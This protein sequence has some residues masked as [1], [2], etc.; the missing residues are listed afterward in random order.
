MNPY[1]KI[2]AS[3]KVGVMLLVLLFTCSTTPT[4]AQDDAVKRGETLFKGNCTS[5]H[6]MWKKMTGPALAGSHEKYEREWLYKW[7]KNSQAL[8]KAGDPQANAIFNEYGGSV[9]TSFA[10]SNEQIDDVL[11]YIADATAKGPQTPVAVEGGAASG[12]DTSGT[13]SMFMGIILLILFAIIFILSR[14]TGTLNNLV[15]EKMGQLV[16]ESVPLERKLFSKKMMAAVSLAGMILLGYYTVGSAQMLGRQQGYQPDQP[17]KFSHELH[18]GV[19]KIDC[20]YCHS[21]AANGK[22]A[23]VPS[24]NVCMNC[25]KAV[26]EGPEHGKKEIQKIYDA[27]GWD[28]EKQAYI[29]GAEEK[30][31]EWVRIHNLPDHVFFSHAQHVTAGGVECQTCHGPIETMA[32]VKQHNSLGMGWCINCHRETNVQFTTNDYYQAYEKYHDDLK[33][34]KIKQVTVEDIGGLECQKCHY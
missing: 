1:Y 12:G 19:N 33:D 21:G 9:M 11:A 26:S 16:P 28:P 2:I 5:C 18:A 29:E 8:V 14:L 4:Y 31:I 15:K 7:I 6:N 32:K 30:P 34:G 10:F 25:H 24:A 13:T 3:A 17:I 27:V 22:S 20:Q 23:V